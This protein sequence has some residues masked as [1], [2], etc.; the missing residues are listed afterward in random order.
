VS[1]FVE[2]LADQ[3]AAGSLAG[4]SDVAASHLRHAVLDWLGVTVAGAVEPS[5]QAIRR[6]LHA[7]GGKPTCSVLG[8]DRRMTATQAALAN[9]VAGHAMD[10][11]DMGLGPCHPSVVILSA[12]AAL[13]QRERVDGAAFA[14]ALLAGYQALADISFSLGREGYERGFHYTGTV[15]TFGAAVACGKLLGFDRAQYVD[16]IGLAATQ[17]AGIKIIF[18]TMAKHLN[19]GRAA[20]NGISAALLA[21]EGFS[22]SADSVDGVQGFAATHSDEVFNPRR[23][24]GILAGRHAVEMLMFKPHASCGGTHSSIESVRSVLAE[25]AIAFDDIAS[26]ELAIPAQLMRM[27]AIP[28]PKTGLEGKFSLRHSVG[29]VL[30]G[31]DTGPAGFTDD[32]VNSPV[33][34][35]SRA[36]VELKPLPG[37]ETADPAEVTVVTRD[38]SRLSASVN[39]NLPTPADKLPE[40]WDLLVR[41]FEGLV[42]PALGAAATAELI[43]RVTSLEH[44][45]SVDQLLSLTEVGAKD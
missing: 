28:E 5:A 38:G 44:L 14:D 1:E 15:G 26:V 35:A 25:H 7:E 36:L 41:K 27:C 13:A 30:L 11:D 3:A 19:A 4:V 42:E 32:A 21:A 17:A 22:A 18:G 8:S 12:T 45:D 40:R 2:H 6:V 34:V 37:L 31:A 16:A 29:L 43:E 20:A 24:D 10:F 39:P 9:G 33:N 23:T